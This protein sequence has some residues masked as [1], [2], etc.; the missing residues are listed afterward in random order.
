MTSEEL[1]KQM[2]EF[3]AKY[4]DGDRSP[5]A[6]PWEVVFVASLALALRGASIFTKE[7]G[8]PVF[9]LKILKDWLV[10]RWPDL[11]AVPGWYITLWFEVHH[12]RGATDEK[13]IL[14]PLVHDL[15][16]QAARLEL[17]RNFPGAAFWATQREIARA[18]M[19]GEKLHLHPLLEPLT[20]WPTPE[21]RPA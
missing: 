4:R 10:P 1:A 13:N 11:T 5:W 2:Y 6:W 12:D 7:Q 14:E 21:A 20:L 19:A 17:T 16:H 15:E 8:L 18:S 9:R 3:M